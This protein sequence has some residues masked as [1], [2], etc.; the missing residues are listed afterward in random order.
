MGQNAGSPGYGVNAA[1][2]AVVYAAYLET[3]HKS[4]M[5]DTSVANMENLNSFD[6]TMN[7]KSAMAEVY[8]D[9]PYADLEPYNVD[10]DLAECQTR[11]DAYLLLTDSADVDNDID[12]FVAA[13]I[14]EYDT[15]INPTSN[16]NDLVNAAEAR[17]DLGLQ[18]SISS[19]ATGARDI[20]AVMTSTFGM[21]IAHLES[22][23]NLA[24]QEEDAKLR[25][26]EER[27]RTES[28]IRLAAMHIQH[29]PWTLQL[30]QNGA[31]MLNDLLRLKMLAKQDAVEFEM[32]MKVRSRLWKLDLFHYRQAALAAINGAVTM[33]RRQTERERKA[34]LFTQALSAGLQAGAAGGPQAGVAT[35]L[36]SGIIG[37]YGLGL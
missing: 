7:V 25:A 27:E 19:M 36:G 2:D 22:Q 35:A 21:A 32:E 10:D 24:L 9:D 14:V 11:L 15:T 30:K 23:K 12:A 20:R 6:R 17:A 4:W 3:E 5:N 8:D 34:A 13:A 31:A 33:P 29:K 26:Y 28:I 37:A 18:R 1:G 16:V